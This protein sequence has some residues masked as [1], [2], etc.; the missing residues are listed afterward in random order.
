MGFGQ[1]VK[2]LCYASRQTDE[3]HI[4]IIEITGLQIVLTVAVLDAYLGV[5]TFQRLGKRT[6]ILVIAAI[7]RT[8]TT[9]PPSAFTDA[10]GHVNA[11]RETPNGKGLR[12]TTQPKTTLKDIANMTQRPPSYSN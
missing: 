9:Q 3:I 7:Q 10:H 6:W 4:T 1:K 12:Y 2:Q 5:P 8:L 11:D